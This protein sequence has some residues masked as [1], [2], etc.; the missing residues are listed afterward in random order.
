MSI[1]AT[2]PRDHVLTVSTRNDT[3]SKP[4][5]DKEESTTGI[6]TL[7]TTP[8]GDNQDEYE[9]N[10]DDSNAQLNKNALV[11]PRIK[12]SDESDSSSIISFNEDSSSDASISS[13][14]STSDSS[15]SEKMDVLP[16]YG[17]QISVK[18]NTVVDEHV[19]QLYQNLMRKS[20]ANRAPCSS[21][22]NAFSQCIGP[23]MI[24]GGVA[25]MTYT[26]YSIVSDE[27][28]GIKFQPDVAGLY[29]LMGFTGVLSAVIGSLCTYSACQ[30]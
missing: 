16:R 22:G 27:K 20:A 10:V 6:W 14:S 5:T 11:K 1:A 29:S 18:I 25:A 19:Q 13:T 2:P 21:P 7:G 30:N 26:I 15:S 8:V 24:L 3:S 4:S 28:N 12:K 23:T 17:E 9:K